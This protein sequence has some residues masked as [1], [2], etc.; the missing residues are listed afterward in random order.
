MKNGGSILG[1]IASNSILSSPSHSML[2]SSTMGSHSSGSLASPSK[3]SSTTILIGHESPANS[4]QAS[5][6]ICR[7]NVSD[8]ELLFG[9]GRLDTFGN[10]GSSHADLSNYCEMKIYENHYKRKLSSKNED[11]CSLIENMSCMAN[12]LDSRLEEVFDYDSNT[13]HYQ[14]KKVLSASAYK[15]S[16]SSDKSDIDLISFTDTESI[17]LANDCG[18][19]KDE[20][21]KKHYDSDGK[22]SFCF[23]SLLI[24]TGLVSLLVNQ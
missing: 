19:R 10:R 14:K 2:T 12:G 7:L 16:S 8:G 17:S 20:N 6:E 1:P 15:Y 13:E 23:D 22:C 3:S 5:N 21:E 18:N 11:Q 4:S 24:C 9:S